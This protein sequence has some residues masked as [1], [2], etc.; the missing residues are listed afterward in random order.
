MFL[1]QLWWTSAAMYRM[2]FLAHL[3]KHHSGEDTWQ[4]ASPAPGC[5]KIS[6]L[7]ALFPVLEEKCWVAIQTVRSRLQL[8]GLPWWIYP[9]ACWKKKMAQ[10]LGAAVSPLKAET[11]EVGPV[12][13]VRGEAEGIQTRQGV[14]RSRRR[15]FHVLSILESLKWYIRRAGPT[16][17]TDLLVQDTFSNPHIN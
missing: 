6:S 9:G 13:C 11:E 16:Q 10:G 14:R 12:V 17:I 2:F 5:S 7:A 4:M 8:K 1:W 15:C 3:L